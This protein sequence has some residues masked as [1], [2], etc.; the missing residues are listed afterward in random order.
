MLVK[1][2]GGKKERMA[3]KE[4]KW[5]SVENDECAAAKNPL[6]MPHHP[7]PY[8]GD[9]PIKKFDHKKSYNP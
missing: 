7:F 3:N 8:P 5:L 2:S 4:K 9:N 6:S 1:L